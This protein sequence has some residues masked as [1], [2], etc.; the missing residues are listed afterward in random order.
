MTTMPTL[1]PGRPRRPTAAAAAVVLALLLLPAAAAAQDG[2]LFRAP[3]VSLTLRGGP[4]LYSTGGDVFDQLRRDLTL[5]RGDFRGPSL[6][7][8]FAILA[9][10]RLDI[11][12]GVT[13]SQ[14]DRRSE[15]R[16]WVGDDDLPIEQVTSL[17]TVPVTASVRYLLVPRGRRIS[18]MAWLPTATTPYIGAG[19]GMTWYRLQQDGEFV[20]F[21][22]FGIFF[23]VL[24]TSGS[25]PVVHALAG[26]DHWFATRFGVNAE[27]R[28]THG[29]ARPDQSFRFF[30]R[31]DLSGVQATLGFSVRW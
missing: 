30:D 1:R 5:D 8:E 16:D 31:L 9:L 28:Y 4:V 20:D 18:D 13:F 10:P 22:D 29:R 27:V 17:R 12:L 15:F 7:A 23:D 21:E 3:A 6:G 19:G 25:H 24:E 2:F 11:V 14:A 26:V